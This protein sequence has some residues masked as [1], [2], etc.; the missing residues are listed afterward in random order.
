MPV[1]VQDEIVAIIERDDRDFRCRGA[2]ESAWSTVKA[3]YPDL[4]WF[5]R[6]STARSLMWEHSV[7]GVIDA[8]AGD[9]DVRAVRHYDTVSF[10]IEDKALVRLKKADGQLATSNFPTPL[11]GL[12]HRHER[13]LF[14]HEGFQRV[15]LVHVFNPLQTEL[16]W[17]GIVASDEKKNVLWQHELRSGGAT[18]VEL[19]TPSRPAPAADTVLRPSRPGVER[20]EEEE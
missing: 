9:R 7:Q 3:R 16:V 14:G 17:I 15:E 2:I 13:D 19:P 5:R 20:R 11:A 6:K 18:V 1:P 8:L 12:F 10:I 4:G